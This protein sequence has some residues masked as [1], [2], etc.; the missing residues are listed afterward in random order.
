MR[1]DAGA[2]PSGDDQELAPKV[3]TSLPRASTGLL[4][5]R[6]VDVRVASCER[7]QFL[8]REPENELRQSQRAGWTGADRPGGAS[9]RAGGPVA[10]T[11]PARERGDPSLFP[12]VAVLVSP[13]HPRRSPLPSS[14]P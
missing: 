5:L 2:L 9:I 13:R 11:P 10:V 3:M 12:R 14:G 6:V 4:N 7:G 1:P 8:G